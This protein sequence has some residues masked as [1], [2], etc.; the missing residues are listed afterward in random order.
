MHL[1]K[2]LFY[3]GRE[4][5]CHHGISRHWSTKSCQLADKEPPMAASL[6]QLTATLSRSRQKIKVIIG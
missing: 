3:S 5:H 6:L 2:K 4:G 1:I